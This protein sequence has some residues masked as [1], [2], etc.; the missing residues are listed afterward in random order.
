MTLYW[1]E[2]QINGESWSICQRALVSIMI[3][4]SRAWCDS[5]IIR[6][7]WTLTEMCKGG[8]LNDKGEN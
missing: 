7:E 5:K 3:C 1:Y 4:P 6:R 8:T 2:R